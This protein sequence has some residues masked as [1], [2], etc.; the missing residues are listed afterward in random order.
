MRL[1]GKR[2]LLPQRNGVGIKNKNFDSDRKNSFAAVL[3]AYVFSFIF[4][5]LSAPVLSAATERKY[6]NFRPFIPEKKD[7]MTE[8][9][10]MWEKQSQY[11]MAAGLGWHI[12]PCIFSKSQTCQQYIDLLGGAAGREGLTTGLIMAGPRWQFVSFPKTYS[13][14]VRVLGGVMSLRDDERD[15]QIFAAALGIGTVVS[16]HERVDLKFELR[17]GHGD[18]AWVQGFVG[19]NFKMEKWLD[20]FSQRL[21]DLGYGTLKAT[22]SAFQDGMKASGAVMDE[23][24]GKPMK[25]AADLLSGEDSQ[26]EQVQ[27][28]PKD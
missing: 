10:A 22:G 13:P 27:E 25:K 14:F 7:Y 17:S 1:D 19:L 24:V 6:T 8:I 16:V 23:V 12:G 20:Y 5:L 11:W 2:E 26:E 15:K 21:I 28:K 18:R 9:G 3:R 4:I